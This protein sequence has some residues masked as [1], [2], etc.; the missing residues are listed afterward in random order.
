MP[1][2]FWV[3]FT[4][5]FVGPSAKTVTWQ[6]KYMHI[7]IIPSFFPSKQNA[8]KGIFFYEQALALSNAGY[9]IG[10]LV[11]RT[12]PRPDISQLAFPTLRTQIEK[13]TDSGITVYSVTGYHWFLRRFPAAYGQFV[14]RL[15]RKLF[16]EYCHELG[17]PDI[18]HAHNTLY[19]GNLASSLKWKSG[20]PLVLTEHDSA[21]FR[22]QIKSQK[23]A[24]V[25]RTFSQVDQL[26]TVSPFLAR[27][28]HKYT[29]GTIQIIG[30]LVDTE[31]FRPA[32]VNLPDEPFIFGVIASLDEN[33]GIDCLLS[34]FATAFRETPVQ[35]VIV[36][37]GPE[38]AWLEKQ[39]IDLGVQNQISFL[40]V[41]N[42]IGIRDFLQNCHVLVSSSY[43]ETFGL[44][45]IEAM[46]CGKP[47]V[48]TRSGG[49]EFFVTEENGIL[50]SAGDVEGLA[51]AMKDLKARYSA[52]KAGKIRAYCVERFSKETIVKQLSVIYEGL[53]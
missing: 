12:T 52:Y 37:D 33:K 35:L 28:L 47:V 21:F 50:V 40:G 30:N 51:E 43:A 27:A 26:V 7:L 38:R 8:M 3:L 6:R 20:I 42:R 15:G 45:L 4:V 31:F 41:I 34:G 25:R 13:T 1:A 16:Q 24:I 23:E 9:K 39:A 36:G 49:P 5:E 22:N 17:S 10:V 32:Q 44:T 19:G 48:S 53:I 18:I 11:V 2:V 14:N 46:A 29:N